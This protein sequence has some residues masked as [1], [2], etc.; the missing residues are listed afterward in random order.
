MLFVCVRRDLIARGER[1][2]KPTRRAL[3]LDR[4]RRPCGQM[5]RGR[6]WK[7]RASEDDAVENVRPVGGHGSVAKWM[8]YEV[9]ISQPVTTFVEVAEIDHRV[10]LPGLDQQIFE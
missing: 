9:T 8:C 3:R 1:W 6:A 4:G 7:H 2:K 10:V 5:F